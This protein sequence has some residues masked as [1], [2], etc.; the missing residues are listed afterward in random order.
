M[1]NQKRLP[2][3]VKRT[4]EE[5]LLPDGRR[6]VKLRQGERLALQREGMIETAVALFLDLQNDHSWDEIANALGI[7]VVTLKKLT[8]S[9]EFTDKYNEHFAD[10]GHDPRLKASQAALVDLLPKA[11]RELGGLVVSDSVSPTVKL[12]A[13]KEVI[14]LN[15][16]EPVGAGMS[17]NAEYAQFL[18]KAGVNVENATINVSLPEEYRDAINNYVDGKYEEIPV[19]DTGTKRQVTVLGDAAEEG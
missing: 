12:G 5:R 2:K 7:S 14:R 6:A 9:Q 8:K 18:K 3:D 15:G 4:L 1:P 16:M 13:I 10:L 19:L 11:I 17:D